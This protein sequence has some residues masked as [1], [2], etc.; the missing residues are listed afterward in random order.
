MG[1][2]V[3]LSRPCHYSRE[4][5]NDGSMHHGRFASERETERKRADREKGRENRGGRERGGEAVSKVP[6]GF[7]QNSTVLMLRA[8]KVTVLYVW[9]K[10]TCD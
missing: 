8:Q 10:D 5:A 2:G 7:L 1:V 9:T 3:G 4:G 6:L